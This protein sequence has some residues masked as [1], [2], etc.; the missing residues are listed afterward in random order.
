MDSRY[1]D[2]QYI[3]NRLKKLEGAIS[4]PNHAPLTQDQTENEQL[5]RENE[6]LKQRLQMA[7]D[8]IR[9]EFEQSEEFRNAWITNVVSY[10]YE[11][12]MAQWAQSPY[13]KKLDEWASARIEEIRAA[14]TPTENPRPVDA[15]KPAKTDNAGGK[16]DA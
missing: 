13:A 14:R 1:Y 16:K 3:E 8:P 6:M 9:V 12:N 2:D 10:L 11:V 7:T 5:R 15:P 4:R